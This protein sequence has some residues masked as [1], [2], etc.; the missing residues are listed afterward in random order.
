MLDWNFSF[1][2]ELEKIYHGMKNRKMKETNEVPDVRKAKQAAAYH[3]KAYIDKVGELR[4][5][6]EY[7]C[8]LEDPFCAMPKKYRD[9]GNSGGFTVKPPGTRPL[10]EEQTESARDIP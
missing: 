6:L 3:I 9:A 8:D 2:K 7:D 5:V 1:L 4:S 10:R